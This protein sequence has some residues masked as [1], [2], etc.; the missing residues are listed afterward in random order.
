MFVVAGVSGHVGS[1]AAKALLAQKQK[2]KVIVR[3][4]AKG[5]EWSKAGAEVAAGAL[6]D[7]AFLT[8]ALRGAAG[9]FTLLPPN[10]QA[11]DFFATQRSTADAIAG[12]VKASGVPHVVLLS[13]IGA[14]LPAGTGPIKGLH[15]LE[16][17]LRA[18]GVKLTAIRAGSFQ[19]NVGNSVAPARQ[20]GIF[21]NFMPSADY[22]IPMI[23]TKDIGALAAQSLLSP[24]AKS[25]V[26]DLVGPA[27]SYR[28]VAEKLGKALG[29]TLQIVDI[30]AAGH[31]DALVKAGFAKSL[32]QEFAEMYSA[33]AGGK[34][35]PKGDRLVQG[36]TEIDEVIRA[37]VG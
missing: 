28:Q 35:V 14:D 34:V 1:V 23:A 7:Q 9:F 33:F 16:E 11:S 36:K 32:A 17:A 21:P 4:P 13:S 25:E 30:P 27:Y 10:Y 6:E 22:P 18:T 8:G 12:A 29:K 20:A 5:S 37:V 3:D 19:E 26:I 24:P 15:Y 31:V 2:I